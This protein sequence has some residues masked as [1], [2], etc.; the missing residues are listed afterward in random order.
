MIHSVK[1]KVK[2]QKLLWMPITVAALVLGCQNTIPVPVGYVASEQ[3]RTW[4]QNVIAQGPKREY[5][6]LVRVMD[7]TEMGLPYGKI[8]LRGAHRVRLAEILKFACKREGLPPNPDTANMPGVEVLASLPPPPVPFW[9]ASGSK[10]SLWGEK[11]H[12]DRLEDD[13]GPEVAKR[14]EELREI[15]RDAFRE[16][17]LAKK[18]PGY[19]KP[20]GN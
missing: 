14:K 19:P 5:T 18:Y 17:D 3:T 8:K 6:S 7:P 20:V 13:Y 2:K 9:E 4:A 10:G 15:F 16:S 11:I 1:G 12:F